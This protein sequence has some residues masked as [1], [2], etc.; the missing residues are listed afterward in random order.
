MKKD[1][2]FTGGSI[3]TAASPFIPQAV[4][5]RGDR[6]CAVGETEQLKR[7]SP[8]PEVFDL[9]GH[10]LLPGFIDSHSHI[11]SFASTLRLVLLSQCRSFDEL[12]EKIASSCKNQKPNSWVTGFGYDHNF[13]AEQRH[14][15][16]VFLDKICPDHPL[17]ISHASGHMGVANSAALQMLGIT[18]DTPDPSGGKIGRMDG[19]TQPNGYLE[20]TAFTQITDRVPKPEQADRINDLSRAQDIY[21][22]YGI[23]TAQD[24][25]TRTDEWNLLKAAANEQRLKMDIVAYPDFIQNRDLLKLDLYRNRYSNHLKIGG[26]KLFLDGSPQGRT[27]WMTEPYLGGEKDYCGYPIHT[28]EELAGW[29]SDALANNIQLLCHC[30]GDAAAEQ[31]LRTY[32]TC[33]GTGSKTRPVMIHAQLVRKNQ[34]SRMAALG[35]IASFFVAH[36]YYWG[37][38]HLQN[39]GAKRANLISPAA[40][41]MK[42]GVVCTFHQD[43]PVLPPHMTDTLQR[44]VERLTK[45]GV[46]LAPEER[47]SIF[48]AVKAVT[49][50]GAYQYFE[51][52]DKGSI[53]IGKRADLVVLDKDILHCDSSEIASAKVLFTFKDGEC[54][55]DASKGAI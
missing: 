51:E 16:K 22:S 15:D 38:V 35:M 55:Y 52:K 48:D 17:I 3:F 6:I 1:I 19:T 30:N 29:V 13:L 26:G 32:E 5:V 41:A 2:L 11:T 23:T 27:A 31:W 7:I 24:G 36:T 44:A 37:D 20:E 9:G 12:A 21:L 53:E 10:L 8:N 34:L 14:P 43:S 39:F 40:S 46:P 45:N 50:N 47:V 33:G 54:V 25:L 42:A 28:D 18:A 4:L 49:T